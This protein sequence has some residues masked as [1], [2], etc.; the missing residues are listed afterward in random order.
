MYFI[1][2]SLEQKGYKCFN[3]STQK[4]QV[5]KNVVFNE[6][7]SWY[8]SMKITKDGKVKNGDVSSNVKQESQLINGPQD[9]SISGSNNIPC[10]G[11][12]KISNIIHGNFEIS[13]KNSHVDGELSDSNNSMD[14]ESKVLLVVTLKV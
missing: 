6:M 4:F 14:E 7:I 12:L 8:S 3:S 10:K 9:F 11:R 13:F 5:G 1:E 2:Y